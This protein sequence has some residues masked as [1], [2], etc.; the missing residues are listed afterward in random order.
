MSTTQPFSSSH[1]F[2]IPPGKV[3]TPGTH[4]AGLDWNALLEATRKLFPGE[5]K[6]TTEFDPEYPEQNFT[7]VHV[8]TQGDIGSIVDRE[9]QWVAMLNQLAPGVPGI[10][11]SIDPGL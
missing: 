2:A 9:S 4:E 11:L 7:V 6:V 1:E 5:L 10:R 3:S 8:S